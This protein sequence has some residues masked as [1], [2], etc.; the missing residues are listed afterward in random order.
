M[1]NGTVHARDVV[2]DEPQG[3]PGVCAIEVATERTVLEALNCTFKGWTGDAV[4]FNGGRSTL[5]ECDFRESSAT[6]L[7]YSTS[8]AEPALVRNSRLGPLNFENELDGSRR[9]TLVNRGT[10][11]RERSWAVCAAGCVPGL[12]GVLCR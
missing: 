5:D 11:C 3:R 9:G 12:A 4:V 10:T 6:T 1:Q 8:S 7:V 2:L